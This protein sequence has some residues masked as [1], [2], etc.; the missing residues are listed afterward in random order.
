MLCTF[1]SKLVTVLAFEYEQ[2]NTWTCSH[3]RVA[4]FASKGQ[5]RSWRHQ[6][7]LSYWRYKNVVKVYFII[8]SCYF[9]WQTLFT[10]CH[11]SSMCMWLVGSGTH[12][13][14]SGTLIG[15]GSLQ[16]LDII[17]PCWTLI[18]SMWQKTVPPLWVVLRDSTLCLPSF[19]YPPVSS[20]VQ[21]N[22]KQSASVIV[23][24]THAGFE[25]VTWSVGHHN[26]FW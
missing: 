9:F 26:H 15:W 2:I 7:L 3:I 21:L 14:M 1:H 20:P 18:C 16:F 23:T 19:L 22:H 25:L 24:A 13:N 10:L 8:Q 5:V 11:I 17:L 12:V 6:M 4:S